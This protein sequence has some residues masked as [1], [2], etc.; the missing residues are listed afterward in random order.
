MLN[1]IFSVIVH[2]KAGKHNSLRFVAIL[3]KCLQTCLKVLLDWPV[4]MPDIG[5]KL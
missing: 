5:C 1:I 4:L 2:R 3:K